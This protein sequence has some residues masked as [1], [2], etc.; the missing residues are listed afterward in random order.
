[1][2]S[3]TGGDQS[4]D[5]ISYGADKR[6][7]QDDIGT[8]E[9][10]VYRFSTQTLKKRL[11][12]INF[13]FVC[14]YVILK[15][16]FVGTVANTIATLIATTIAVQNVSLIAIPITSAHIYAS[17]FNFAIL[18]ATSASKVSITPFI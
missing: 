15:L 3:D 9:L 12:S 16:S 5:N 4:R 17:A 8:I 11:R 14:F 10:E 6:Q 2:N 13:K 1:M 7:G 18:T